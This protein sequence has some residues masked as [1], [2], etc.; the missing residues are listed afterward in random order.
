ME[1]NLKNKHL[2]WIGIKPAVGSALSYGWDRMKANF[3]VFFVVIIALAVIGIPYQFLEYEMDHGWRH[4]VPLTLIFLIF[5]Y[6]IL[7]EPIIEYGGDLLFLQGTRGDKVEVKDIVIG[8][9]NYINIVL[10]NILLLGLIGISFF[11]LIIPGII[12][13]VR[14]VFVSYLVMDE[15]LNPIEAVETSWKITKGHGWKIFLLGIVSFFIAILGLLVLIVGIFPAVMW[16]KASFASL[17]LS[18]TGEKASPDSEEAGV[19]E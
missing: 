18:I 16:I 19:N 6:R 1:N 9:K 5:L 13:S 4:D 17:Y 2:N 7:F 11:L 8:F 10:V 14:L 12:V 3:L 15:G